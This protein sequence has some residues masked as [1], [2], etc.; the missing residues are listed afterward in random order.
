M[1]DSVNIAATLNDS[2]YVADTLGTS[3]RCLYADWSPL[4]TIYPEEFLRIQG[5][6]PK[7]LTKQQQGRLKSRF[8]G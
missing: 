3:Q 4:P 2:V 5:A 1:F 7:A 6:S 8:G